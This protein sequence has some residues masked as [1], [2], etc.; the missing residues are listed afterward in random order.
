VTVHDCAMR[1]S[2]AVRVTMTLSAAQSEPS[3]IDYGRTAENI[4]NA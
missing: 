4:A 2:L 3:I 1:H